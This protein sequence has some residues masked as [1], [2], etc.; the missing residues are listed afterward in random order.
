MH[1]RANIEEIWREK[2]EINMIFQIL[3]KKREFYNMNWTFMMET[4]KKRA[5]KGESCVVKHFVDVRWE[6]NLLITFSMPN[7]CFKLI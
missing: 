1:I 6:F 7:K 2:I 5:T 4:S 3:L